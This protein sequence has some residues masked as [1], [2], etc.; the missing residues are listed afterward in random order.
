MREIQQEIR[1]LNPALT[2]ASA[3]IRFFRVPDKGGEKFDKKSKVKSC[4]RFSHE[5]SVVSDQDG[6]GLA[7]LYLPRFDLWLKIPPTITSV[8]RSVCVFFP[9]VNDS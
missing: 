5:I 8:S 9:I 2:R 3:G 1:K 4:G 6:D 7:P